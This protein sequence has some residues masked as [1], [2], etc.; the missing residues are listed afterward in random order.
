[1]I[2]EM[3]LEAAKGR[4]IVFYVDEEKEALYPVRLNELDLLKIDSEICKI[5]MGKGS[6]I[7]VLDRGFRLE[8]VLSNEERDSREV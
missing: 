5:F 7:Q 4:F 3:N 1:M 6:D 2:G 8:E